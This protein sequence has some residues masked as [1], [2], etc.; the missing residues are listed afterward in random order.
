MPN[1]TTHK[2]RLECEDCGK[3]FKQ[4]QKLTRH[5]ETH[6]VVIPFGCKLCP[7]RFQIQGRLIRHIRT[8]DIEYSLTDKTCFERYA[9][10]DVL[11]SSKTIHTADKPYNCRHCDFGSRYR[12]SRNNHEET[13]HFT[14]QLAADQDSEVLDSINV[15]TRRLAYANS[16]SPRKKVQLNLE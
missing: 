9:R 1:L 5:F 15:H 11:A 6:N 12:C 8:H 2:R 7:K 14:L 3:R 13:Q 4:R 10:K 16:N